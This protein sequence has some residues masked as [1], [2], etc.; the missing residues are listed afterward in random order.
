MDAAAHRPSVCTLFAKVVP[1]TLHGAPGHVDLGA[2]LPG[3]LHTRPMSRRLLPE[4]R[5]ASGRNSFPVVARLS[6]GAAV[7]PS[8][9]GFVWVFRGREAPVACRRV[10]LPPIHPRIPPKIPQSYPLILL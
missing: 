1:G 10:Q 2:D 8:Q 9:K 7:F 4:P 5:S 3:R 6:D